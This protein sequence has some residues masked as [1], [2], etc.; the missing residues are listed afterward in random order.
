MNGIKDE[1]LMK[2]A[3]PAKDPKRRYRAALEDEM[4]VELPVAE[5]ERREE[6]WTRRLIVRSSALDS[7]DLAPQEAERYLAEWRVSRDAMRDQMNAQMRARG[8]TP[9][10]TKCLLETE[11]QFSASSAPSGA[12]PLAPPPSEYDWNALER[13]AGR[14]IPTDLK[15]LYSIS[16]GGFGPGITGL[17]TVQLIKAGSKDFRRRGP[18]YCGTVKYTNFYLHLAGENLDFYYDLGA[19]CNISCNSNWEEQGLQIY[20][21]Y[22]VAFGSLAEMMEEWLCRS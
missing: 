12:K 3:E 5:I 19:N 22:N 14:P 18:D 15:H 11:Q 8:Q 7:N 1:L 9:P 4:R 17:N 6:E 10:E 13:F 20:E 16:D 2:I 21:I